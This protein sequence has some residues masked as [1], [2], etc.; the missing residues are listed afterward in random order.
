MLWERLSLYRLKFP[1][2]GS[3]DEAC[4]ASWLFVRIHGFPWPA[5][6]IGPSEVSACLCLNVKL[7]CRGSA[8]V[9]T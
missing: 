3:I 9:L 6:E 7:Q 1:T 4:F 8:H 2:F 5:I